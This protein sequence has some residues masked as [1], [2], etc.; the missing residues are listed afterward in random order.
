MR[1]FMNSSTKRDILEI[2]TNYA[3]ITFH[4]MEVK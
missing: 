3:T 1:G 4:G 2:K